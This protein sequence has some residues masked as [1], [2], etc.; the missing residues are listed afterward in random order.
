MA[1]R[2]TSKSLH[3]SI[4]VTTGSSTRPTASRSSTCAIATSSGT[5]RIGTPGGKADSRRDGIAADRMTNSPQSPCAADQP[6]ERLRQPGADDAVVIRAA[7][8]RHPPRRVEH[9]RARPRHAF[10]HHQPQRFAGHVDAVA[11]RIGAEQRGARV[12]AEDVDQRAGVDRID[13]LGKQ[14][15]AVAGEAVGDPRMDRLQ[16]LDRG[17]QAERAAPAASISR[18]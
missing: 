10:H 1:W 12:V 5:R 8:A 9:G 11:Q 18:A 16:P 4:L 6:A 7:A 14:R 2:S 13:M 3:A 17:E 15:Q